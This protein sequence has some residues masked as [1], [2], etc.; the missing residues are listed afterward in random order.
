LPADADYTV[1]LPPSPSQPDKYI[2]ATLRAAT[3]DQP[4]RFS[5]HMVYPHEPGITHALTG[6]E[7]DWALAET[8][9]F[10]AAGELFDT[11]EE[12]L[13]ELGPLCN[14]WGEEA[15]ALQHYLEPAL[16]HLG[17]TPRTLK[18]VG[19]PVSYTPRDT[20]GITFEHLIDS[21]HISS[22]WNSPLTRIDFLNGLVVWMASYYEHGR[23]ADASIY[24][25]WAG[26]V[27]AEAQTWSA[28]TAVALTAPER[29]RLYD[30]IRRQITPGNLVRSVC[31]GKYSSAR[32]ISFCN[33][34]QPNYC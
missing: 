30:A 29:M 12:L 19:P 1:S 23:L 9:T 22:A 18:E 28:M 20:S 13:Q 5:A 8:E 31:A 21:V 6:D 24:L 16:E 17:V 25:R 33:V 4:A 26:G 2:Q 11:T 32:H 27:Q 15:E 10:V 7:L 3:N 34:L 14:V